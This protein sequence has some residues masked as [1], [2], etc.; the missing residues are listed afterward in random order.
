MRFYSSFHSILI[1][2]RFNFAISTVPKVYLNNTV[3]HGVNTECKTCPYVLCPN[4]LYYDSD[5]NVTLTCFTTG[6]EI[7]GDSIWLGT[8][9]GCYVTQYDLVLYNGSYSTTLAPCSPSPIKENITTQSATIKYDTECNITP[10]TSVDT[11]HYLKP[12][13]D[14]TVTCWTNDS[15]STVINDPM[16]LKTT[17][18]CYVAQIGLAHPANTSAL[19]FCG[20]IPFLEL[21]NAANRSG[22]DSPDSP[23]DPEDT[24]KPAEIPHLLIR[25]ANYLINVTVCEDYAYCRS[26]PHLNCTVERAYEFGTQ[27]WLQCLVAS[28][29][30]NET[31]WSE[32]TDWCFVRSEDLWESPEGDY[33]KFPLCSDFEK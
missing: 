30:P 9:D 32:T 12:N 18:N 10:S 28:T 6:T 13:T 16:W 14:I 24:D 20:P 17:Q 23:T 3:E 2:S 15:T 29:A 22:S 7:S 1:L 5:V 27:I 4:K 26:C 11:V 8:S 25:S 19:D 31:F 21:I 33:Y